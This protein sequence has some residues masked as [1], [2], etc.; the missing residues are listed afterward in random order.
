M[1]NRIPEVDIS[2]MVAARTFPPYPEASVGLQDD[3]DVEIETIG[4]A[5]QAVLQPITSVAIDRVEN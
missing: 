5:V 1:T 3:C 2:A 4:D